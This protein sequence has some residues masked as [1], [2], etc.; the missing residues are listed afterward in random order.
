MQLPDYTKASL[1][2]LYIPFFTLIGISTPFYL[3]DIDSIVEVSFLRK[4]DLGFYT[5][6]Q[7]E[8]G[9]LFIFFMEEGRD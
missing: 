1:E 3:E 4:I 5:Y 8:S 7:Y 2:S 9:K 6:F